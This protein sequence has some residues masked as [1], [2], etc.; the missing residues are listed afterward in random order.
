MTATCILLAAMSFSD[1]AA[2][3]RT[4][5]A[6]AGDVCATGVVTQVVGWRSASGV[7]ADPGNPCGRGIYFSGELQ[8]DPSERVD[9][10]AGFKVGDL[11]EVRGETTPLAFAPGVSA[12]S[13]RRIGEMPLPPFREAKLSEMRDGRLDNARVKIKGVVSGVRQMP[14]VRLDPNASVVQLAVSSDEGLFLAHVPGSAEEWRPILDAEVEVSGCAMSSFSVRAEFRGV[15]MEVASPEDVVVTKAAPGSPFDRE[16]TS[17][18]DLMAFSPKP[19][20]SHARKVRGVVT[21]SEPGFC[22]IQDGEHGLKVVGEDAGEFRPGD[23]V[24]VVGSPRVVDRMSELRCMA[25]RR[26]G[27]GSL[28]EPFEGYT[29]ADYARW[30]YYSSGGAMVDIEWR[31]VAFSARVIRADARDGS[32]ELILTDGSVTSRVRFS[33]AAPDFLADAE[34]LRPLVRVCAVAEPSVSDA[35]NDDRMPVLRGISFAAASPDD[36]TFVPDAEWR[37]RKRETYSRNAAWIAVAFLLALVAVGVWSIL[38]ARRERDRIAAITAE[39][40]RMAA[41]LHDT[42]EQNLAGAKMLMESSLSIA[43]DVPPA[44]EEAVKG[45]AAVLAHAKSEIRA[46]IFNLRCD[47]MFDRRPEDV[48]REMMRHLDRGVVNARCRLRGMPDHLPG[49]LF[50]DLIG[51][52]QESTTNAI[53]H[54]R[55]KNIVLVSDPLTGDG[56][57]GFALRVLNDGEPFDAASALGPEAGH[58]GLAGMRERAKRNGMRILWE[59]EGRWTS[60]RVEVKTS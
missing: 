52:V 5:A 43:P 50:S 7:F 35:T 22:Y 6:Q 14:Q 37:A 8:Q 13:I 60:V 53:K 12:S 42:I 58:F 45:A 21:Y 16:T 2:L 24:E 11:I 1:V 15:Q 4:E 9:A 20:D 30:M 31:R 17:V 57:R 46:T 18:A 55:A 59:T 3:T 39:R 40:K 41:D 27:A 47:E 28:P 36:I 48:F 10:A 25:V 49:A 54:G 44:V 19:R 23:E 51:I 38:R 32:A 33:G 29:L 26:T 56:A 34:R